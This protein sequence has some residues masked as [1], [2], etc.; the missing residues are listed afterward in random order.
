VRGRG[1]SLADR[2]TV[3]AFR[4]FL[5][6]PA[7]RCGI[8]LGDDHVRPSQCPEVTDAERRVIGIMRMDVNMAKRIAAIIDG[9]RIRKENAR[10]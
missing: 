9:Q 1:L 4:A 3:G 8:C 7:S 10:G 5:E 6:A 2:E